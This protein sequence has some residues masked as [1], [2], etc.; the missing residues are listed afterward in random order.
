MGPRRRCLAAPIIV[1]VLHQ[2][3]N[4]EH[5]PEARVLHDGTLTDFP[6]AIIGRAGQCSVLGTWRSS[7]LVAWQSAA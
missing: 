4:L 2:L 7:F 6:Q 5:M 1:L 3:C